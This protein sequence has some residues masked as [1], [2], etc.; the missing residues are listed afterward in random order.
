MGTVRPALATL[1]AVA[2]TAAGWCLDRERESISLLYEP[3]PVVTAMRSPEPALESPA[4]LTVFT[5]DQIR[6][7]GARTLPE[8]LEFAP[9]FIPLRSV[10]GDWWPGPRGILDSN[11]SFQVMID[12]ISIN[13]QF[14]GSPYWTYDLLD[15]SR[16]SRI[17]IVRGPGSALY[18]ANAFLA[19][20]N[21]ITDP[22][23]PA[24]GA[25]STTVGTF[26]TRGIALSRVFKTRQT[27]F[28]LQASGFSGDGQ[29]RHIPADI[30]GKPG[31][32][33]DGFTK[34]D[35]MLKISGRRGWTFLAHHVEGHREGYLGYFDNANDQTFFRRSN[36]LL[37]L[38]Y[39]RDLGRGGDMTANVFWNR[40]SD[41]EDAQAIS[42]GVSL[43]DGAIEGMFPGLDLPNPVTYPRGARE[44]DHS[45]DAVFGVNLLWQSR[46]HG[47][48]R[49]SAGAETTAI[50][51]AES[52]VFG[53]FATPDDPHSFRFMPGRYPEPD[54]WRNHSF[55]LQDDISLSRRTRLVVGA[56][57]DHHSE[58]GP[59]LH[60]RIGL[61]NR[62]SHRWTGKLLYGEAFRNPDFHE[63][64]ANPDRQAERIRTVEGQLLGEL[65]DGWFTKI[66]VFFNDLRDRIESA[67]TEQDY[68]TIDETQLVGLESEV[69]KRFRNGQELFGNLSTV[70][71]QYESSGE[72]LF[73]RQPHNKLNLGYSFRL[74]G[75]DTCVWGSF[76]AKWN[77]NWE[78]PRPPEPGFRL[79]H[80]TLQKKG[81][82]GPADRILL[83]VRNLLNRSYAFPSAWF[84]GAMVE[85]YPQTGREMTLEM[86]WDL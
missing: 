57:R 84:P 15:L 85:K 38:R 26:N 78:D 9:G 3:E 22:G 5:R 42:P 18:G 54:R 76:T 83:R 55:T 65:H 1:L 74:A 23:P 82:P 53:S 62:L 73:P 70:F 2:L 79:F 58:F 48:H 20:I 49:C 19:V 50:D 4:I 17:E 11:R 41:S 66:N 12:G 34:R 36:D 80:L 10:S 31:E 52:A 43:P 71:R 67:R 86:S 32:T 45:R 16:F 60:P 61:I 77:R 35:L 39:R 68:R 29:R 46:P 37:S 59:S 56:R 7:L 25:L 30:Y 69:R 63:L 47:R 6:S 13:N 8:L 75:F 33:A 44:L 64:T 51:L 14:L 21:C 24:G 72:T 28:D 81:F 40:F 27:T